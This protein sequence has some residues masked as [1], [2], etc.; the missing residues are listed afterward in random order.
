VALL[1]QAL[2]STPFPGGNYKAPPLQEN[3]FLVDS[4]AAVPSAAELTARAR[5][6]DRRLRG[7]GEKVVWVL[8]LF[9]SMEERER[10]ARAENDGMLTAMRNG[11]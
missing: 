9:E 10:M 3:R 7:I 1:S 5:A 11:A 8:D 6:A 2:A 4:V